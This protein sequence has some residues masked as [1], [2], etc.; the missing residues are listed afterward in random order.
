MITV[1]LS[2][3]FM[4]L[5]VTIFIFLPFLFFIALHLGFLRAPFELFN[6]RIFLAFTA[7]FLFVKDDWFL[8]WQPD[9]LLFAASFCHKKRHHICLYFLMP[10]S[11]YCTGY[12]ICPRKYNFFLMPLQGHLG[13][14]HEYAT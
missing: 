8:Q 1:E 10:F 11:Q 13:I 12:G 7:Q 5:R 14:Y 9:S 6:E 2:P 3:G 4:S